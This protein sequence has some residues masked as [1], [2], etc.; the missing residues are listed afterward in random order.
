MLTY[1]IIQTEIKETHGRLVKACWIAHVK[2]MNGLPLKL[3]HNRAASEPRK[4]PCPDWAKPL[5][6]SVMQK[7][8]MLPTKGKKQ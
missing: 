5:I 4:Y 1:K 7:H 3:S 8:G 6:E 2:E